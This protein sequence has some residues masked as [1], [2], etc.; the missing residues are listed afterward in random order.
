MRVRSGSAGLLLCT[1]IVSGVLAL[2]PAPAI[3]AAGHGPVL[4][5]SYHP[6]GEPL[7]LASDGHG[8]IWY[9]GAATYAIS[10]ESEAESSI[11]HL[12]AG[13]GVTRLQLP[14]KPVSR[15]APYFATGQDGVE[16]FLAETDVNAA[17]S[18]AGSLPRASLR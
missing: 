3:A 13:G 15:F 12:T 4:G 18:W 6:G 7:V 11:W 9:G 17:W 16:W 1:G 8:G 10:Q 2:T 5:P 14:V